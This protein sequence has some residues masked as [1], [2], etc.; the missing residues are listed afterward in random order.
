ML[1]P[2][3]SKDPIFICACCGC[4]CGVLRNLKLHEK[5]AELVSNPFIARHDPALCSN[6]GVC[7]ERCQ[8]DAITT[9][10]N[11]AE[12]NLD[13]CI[14]CGLCVSTCP[15]GALSLVRKPEQP[16]IPKDTVSNYLQ[17][18]Q[19]RNMMSTPRL[20]GTLLKSK[21]DRLIAPR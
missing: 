3:N 1:Q 5:P 21:I 19:A 13:R 11:S 10:L 15:S 17:L 7:S 18:G 8:M 14:G 20:A 12:L 16:S 4:C 2:S 9:G 6:C